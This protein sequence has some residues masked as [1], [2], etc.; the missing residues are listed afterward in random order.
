MVPSYDL[1]TKL[2]RIVP[3]QGSNCVESPKVMCSLKDLN[4]RRKRLLPWAITPLFR[5]YFI[6]L[7]AVFLLSEL[8]F[9]PYS[10]ASQAIASSEH[11]LKALGFKSRRRRRYYNNYDPEHAVPAES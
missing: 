3:R 7:S 8:S 9:L 4:I 1:A 6:T 10:I 11:I 2:P 5:T